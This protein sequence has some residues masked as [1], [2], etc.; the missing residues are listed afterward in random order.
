[1]SPTVLADSIL[2]HPALAGRTLMVRGEG[3]CFSIDIQPG[4]SL[5]QP[6]P[7]EPDTIPAGWREG[8]AR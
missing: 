2:I 8:P 1:M 3:G 7:L 4:G 6:R 5:G